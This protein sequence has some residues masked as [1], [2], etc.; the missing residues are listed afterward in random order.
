MAYMDVSGLYQKYGLEQV[1]PQ[2]G[3]EYLSYG[4]TREI[5]FKLTLTDLTATPTVIKGM[6]NVFMPAGFTVEQV[7]IIV[8]TAAATG[9]SIDIG[10]QRTDRTTTINS[11]G[12]I[13]AEVLATLTPAGKKIVYNVGTS[14][15]GALVGASVGVNPGYFTANST[16]TLFT[17]GVLTVRVKYCKK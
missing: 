15:A 2:A 14:K 16:A 7:E 4:E 13:A 10:F 5:E 12:L 17:A 11:T 6:D 3:G 8:E 9:V 1:V